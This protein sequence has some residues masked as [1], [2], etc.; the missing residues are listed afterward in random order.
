MCQS[1]NINRHPKVKTSI[2]P[3]D[4][5]ISL[6]KIYLIK[7]KKNN[8]KNNTFLLFQNQPSSQSRTMKSTILK[9]FTTKSLTLRMLAPKEPVEEKKSWDKVHEPKRQ[10]NKLIDDI[11]MK[12]SSNYNEEET[13]YHC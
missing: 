3:I 8:K 11:I 4:R 7:E 5:L 2:A 1:Q 10:E 6:E 13:N 9:L 12:T